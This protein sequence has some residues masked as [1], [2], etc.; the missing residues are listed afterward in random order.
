MPA[1]SGRGQEAVVGVACLVDG[2]RQQGQFELVRLVVHPDGAGPG[3][4]DLH[5]APEEERAEE[6][7]VL[8]Q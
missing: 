5:D 3:R 8:E 6:G 7:G 2:R 1:E 4:A